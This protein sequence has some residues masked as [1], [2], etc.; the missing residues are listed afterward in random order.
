[1]R[2]EWGIWACL[3]F[4]GGSVF[5]GTTWRGMSGFGGAIVIWKVGLGG[6]AQLNGAFAG[7]EVTI[8]SSQPF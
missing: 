8:F 7:C 1:M 2:V 6:R 3:V 4:S 5:I